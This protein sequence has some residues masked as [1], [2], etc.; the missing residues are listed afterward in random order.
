MRAGWF[1]IV[2]LLA[3]CNKLFDVAGAPTG[4]GGGGGGGGGAVDARAGGD[5]I[6]N[7]NCPSDYAMVEGEPSYYRFSD[8]NDKLAWADARTTC[9]QDTAGLG[10]SRYTHLVVLN[11]P[12]AY[13][14]LFHGTEDQRWV[15]VSAA[16]DGTWDWV[17]GE[18]GFL[19]WLYE[20]ATGGCG[21]IDR[22][23]SNTEIGLISLSCTQPTA[24][25]CA[26]DII[27][28]QM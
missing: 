15:G 8:P 4:G 27:P 14:D 20:Q 23:P 18:S 13:D 7:A 2:A 6:T 28:D 5:G 10:T 9:I 26:C 25:V 17:T 24:F 16:S 11:G 12:A 22:N 19:E 21:A 3:G 1:A